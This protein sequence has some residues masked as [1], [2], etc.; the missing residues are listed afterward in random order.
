M[1]H[2]LGALLLLLCSP[3][4]AAGEPLR[5]LILT[6]PGVYHNYENQNRVLAAGIARHAN[7]RFDIS[8]AEIDRWREGDFSDG[9]DVLVYNLC[10]ADNADADLIANLRRQTEELGT[11]AVVLHCTMHSFRDTDLWWPLYGL[12]TVR[13]EPLGPL[14]QTPVSAHPILTGIPRDWVLEEDELYNNIT[15]E[16][17]PLLR[18]TAADGSEHTTAWLKPRGDTMVFGTTAGHSDAS[19]ADPHY[20]QLLANALLYVTGKL[21]PQGSPLAG[22][23]GTSQATDAIG[24]ISAPPGVR[25]LGADGMDC[26]R[27][28]FARS[29]GPCYVGCI[30]HPLRW[31]ESASRCREDCNAKLPTPDEAIALC[32][33]DA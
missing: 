19:V 18:A 28:E 32:M 29:A 5:A 15:F 8:L 14:R 13:H 4:S 21:D 6:S 16:A 30:L 24:T 33:P 22:Y 3:L 27:G 9:Y 7:V 10:M 25:F 26:V 31:G 20:Q 2:A 23:A 12:K 17:Q 11:P 1:R